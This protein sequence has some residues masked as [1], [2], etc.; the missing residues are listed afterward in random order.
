MRVLA[1]KDGPSRPLCALDPVR[2][3]EAGVESDTPHGSRR[4][5]TVSAVAP[6]AQPLDAAASE[7]GEPC[8]LDFASARDE[9][10][11]LIELLREPFGLPV[12]LVVGAARAHDGHRGCPGEAN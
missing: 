1:C 3:F 7:P 2:D 6:F 8:R 11:L 9:E 4:R 12:E 10:A 5:R